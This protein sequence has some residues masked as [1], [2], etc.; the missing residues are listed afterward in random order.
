MTTNDQVDHKADPFANRNSCLAELFEAMM[1]CVWDGFQD[2]SCPNLDKDQKR[3][4]NRKLY[5]EFHDAIRTAR[6]WGAKVGRFHNDS[7]FLIAT[8]LDGSTIKLNTDG[9]GLRDPQPSNVD[10]PTP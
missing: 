10:R 9:S 2:T 8:F 5:N 7:D 6:G 4:N 1:P 3:A